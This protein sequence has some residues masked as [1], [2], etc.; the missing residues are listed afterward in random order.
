MVECNKPTEHY[1]SGRALLLAWDKIIKDKTLSEE[2][3]LKAILSYLLYDP[4]KLAESPIT[5][6]E[7]NFL[8]DCNQN[9]NGDIN[10]MCPPLLPTSF[11]MFLFVVGVITLYLLGGKK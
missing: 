1:S 4:T 5:L 10:K 11:Y 3:L 6:D 9:Y 7:V 2:E 8:Y